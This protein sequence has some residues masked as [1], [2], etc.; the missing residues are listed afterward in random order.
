MGTEYAGR[1][2]LWAKHRPLPRLLYCTGMAGRRFTMRRPSAM[3]RP[4]ARSSALAQRWTSRTTASSGGPFV[5]RVGAGR[6]G[7]GR[8]GP[9]P[10]P[11][12]PPPPPA[13]RRRRCTTPPKKATP[14]QRPRCSAPARTRPSRTKTGTPCRAAPHRPTATGRQPPVSRRRTAEEVAQANGHSGAYAAAVAQARGRAARHRLPHAGMAA[15]LTFVHSFGTFS[16]RHR[17][18]RRQRCSC[19]LASA[20]PSAERDAPDR[21]LLSAHSCACAAVPLRHAQ[22]GRTNTFRCHAHGTQDAL[23]MHLSRPLMK[24]F[25]ARSEAQSELDMDD[26]DPY[27]R[28]KTSS[29]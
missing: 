25:Q 1:G 7:A 5:G 6:I 27:G 23:R 16:R 19:A 2:A 17:T 24:L 14:T 26:R 29:P 22:R 18:P 11:V 12:P 4:S 3:C 28:R 8:R 20:R 15:A 9:A 10:P 13:G 21:P